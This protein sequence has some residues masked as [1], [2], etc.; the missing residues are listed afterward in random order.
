MKST[1]GVAMKWTSSSVTLLE[2]GQRLESK[3]DFQSDRE[4]VQPCWAAFEKRQRLSRT[5]G[6]NGRNQIRI[7][8]RIDL[9]SRTGQKRKIHRRV[10][11]RKTNAVPD[12]LAHTDIE[13]GDDG[14]VL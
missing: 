11:D 8:I 4:S 1:E 13:L 3:T 7:H 2:S 5:A 9:L 12:L 14:P 6:H 10:S